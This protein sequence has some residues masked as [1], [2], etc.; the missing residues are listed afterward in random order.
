MAKPIG[1][2]FVYDGVEFFCEKCGKAIRRGNK[3][4]DVKWKKYRKK[5][6]YLVCESCAEGIT[7]EWEVAN[8]KNN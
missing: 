1:Y 5:G 3:W 7:K 8:D 2:I 4:T 6:I